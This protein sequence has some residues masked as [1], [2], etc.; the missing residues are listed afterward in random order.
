MV[1]LTKSL[2]NLHEIVSQIFGDCWSL[3]MANTYTLGLFDDSTAH[4]YT[5]FPFNE[6]NCYRSDAILQNVYRDN[7]FEKNLDIFVDKFKNMHKCNI[8]FPATTYLPFIQCVV[9]ENDTVELKGIE[10]NIAQAIT[11][12]LNFTPN[13]MCYPLFNGSSKHILAM[14]NR[15]FLFHLCAVFK[16]KIINKF[17]DIQWNIKF[18]SRCNGQQPITST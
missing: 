4:L 13:I 11:D 18:H 6:L 8:Y 2:P 17:P 5:Y 16:K 15:L 12:K 3:Y 7:R 10:G 14:V 9:N 1:V